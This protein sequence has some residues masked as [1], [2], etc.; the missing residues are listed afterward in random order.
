MPFLIT[1][2]SLINS[3]NKITAEVIPQFITQIQMYVITV[4]FLFIA[5]GHQLSVKFQFSTSQ[6]H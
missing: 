2:W 3:K 1:L 5:V 6:F 4:N